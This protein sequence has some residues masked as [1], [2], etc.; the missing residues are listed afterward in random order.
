MVK[1]AI[2]LCIQRLKFLL[3]I[4]SNWLNTVLLE[5]TLSSMHSL[6]H[7]GL[8]N[9]QKVDRAEILWLD[10]TKTTI[11]NPDIDKK[12]YINK[13]AYQN[14]IVEKYKFTISIYGCFSWNWYFG[15]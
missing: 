13:K 9:I 6:A 7:F 3:I 11:Y 12:H 10:G 4:K 1:I 15:F 8:G 2:V 14:S 5:A